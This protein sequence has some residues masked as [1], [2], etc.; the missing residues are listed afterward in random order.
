MRH[1]LL[2]MLDF[3]GVAV[4]RAQAAA[5]LGPGGVLALALLVKR[6]DAPTPEM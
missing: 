4:A 2:V 5:A 3:A 1:G 6:F